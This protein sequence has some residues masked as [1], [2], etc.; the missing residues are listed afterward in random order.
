MTVAN[1]PDH[2]LSLEEWAALPED[3]VHR[4]E[5]VEGV[6]QVCARPL[7][8]HQR[9]IMKLSHQL[10]RQLPPELAVAPEVEV[11]LERRT[12]ATVR[13]PDL[14]VIPSDVARTNP[15][16][17][18]AAVVSLAVEVVSPGS[19]RLDRVFKLHEYAEAGIPHYWIVELEPMPVI[20]AFTLAGDHY[21]LSARATDLLTVT[22][23]AEL[24]IAVGELTP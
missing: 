12:P 2:L 3:D 13:V 20:S 15:A 24:S 7:F 4:Y 23:P 6:L 14:I 22:E 21:E 9:A 5:L 18:D 1:I 16:R 8:N 17:S 10:D 11:V 19:A